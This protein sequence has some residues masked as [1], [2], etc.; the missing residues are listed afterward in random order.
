MSTCGFTIPI[1]PNSYLGDSLSTINS[2]MS[3][4][5]TNSCDSSNLISYLSNQISLLDNSILNI[6]NTLTQMVVNKNNGTSYHLVTSSTAL[7]TLTTI[8]ANSISNFNYD[9]G[10]FTITPT[11]GISI[12]LLSGVSIGC[13]NNTGSILFTIDGI[14]ITNGMIPVINKT[15][16]NYS[17]YYTPNCSHQQYKIFL[18]GYI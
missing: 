11:V 2:N 4:L 1:D 5:D 14:P 9:T 15:T 6:N 18:M 10:S 16:Y 12:L 17:W 7:A 8:N 13:S 3:S